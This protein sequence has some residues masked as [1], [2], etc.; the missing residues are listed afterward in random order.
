MLSLKNRTTALKSC[1][2]QD[3][4]N[5]KAIVGTV[6]LV[7]SI[8]TAFTNFQK[9]TL[10]CHEM[11]SFTMKKDLSLQPKSPEFSWNPAETRQFIEEFGVVSQGFIPGHD[12]ND[13]KS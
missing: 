5:V 12:S 4:D 7:N 6:S 8:H 2:D 1:F 10:S 3:L 13:D 11:F 9:S